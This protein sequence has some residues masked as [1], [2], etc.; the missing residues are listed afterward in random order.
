MKPTAIKALKLAYVLGFLPLLLVEGYLCSWILLLP[1]P[2]TTSAS[3]VMLL[4]VIYCAI[5][6]L[7]GVYLGVPHLCRRIRA[8]KIQFS[9]IYLLGFI[10]L[11]ALTIL[12]FPDPWTVHGHPNVY[13]FVFNWFF[14]GSYRFM[15]PLPLGM[16]LSGFCLAKAF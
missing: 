12:L 7:S 8:K 10:I 13:G 14:I 4:I 9:F 3:Q 1:A 11:V 6:F 15:I 2:P 16:I 5:S